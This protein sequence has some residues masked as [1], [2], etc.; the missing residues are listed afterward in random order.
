MMGILVL[1]PSYFK[2]RDSQRYTE[3]VFNEQRRALYCLR[4]HFLS[5]LKLVVINTSCDMD[6]GMAWLR[7][8]RGEEKLVRRLCFL[9]KLFILL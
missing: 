3:D 5:P 6:N 8:Q 4:G 1:L 2:M 9:Q 7:Q